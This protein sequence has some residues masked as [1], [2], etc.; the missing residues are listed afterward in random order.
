MPRDDVRIG[1]NA[2][3]A[4]CGSGRHGAG[5]ARW[6]HDTTPLSK[7]GQVG[8]LLGSLLGPALGNQVLVWL[9]GPLRWYI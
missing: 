9:W 5:C 7:E 2:W 8:A 3:P 1:A 4:L 6:D